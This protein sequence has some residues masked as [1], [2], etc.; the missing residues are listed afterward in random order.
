MTDSPVRIYW[1]DDLA[2]AGYVDLAR[3]LRAADIDVQ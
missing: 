3:G 2:R 1:K